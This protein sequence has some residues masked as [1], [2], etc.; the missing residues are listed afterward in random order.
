MLEKLKKRINTITDRLLKKNNI[1]N[2]INKK[3]ND[4]QND[5]NKEAF[6]L[7][8]DLNELFQIVCNGHMLLLRD[9][10]P[11]QANSQ[12]LGILPFLKKIKNEGDNN[13]VREEIKKYIKDNNI[14]R[15]DNPIF[16]AMVLAERQI[17]SDYLLNLFFLVK[18]NNCDSGE[19]DK[20]ANNLFA[21]M[22]KLSPAE[23]IDMF[24]NCFLSIKCFDL[25]DNEVYEKSLNTMLLATLATGNEA[26]GKKILFK[27]KE[28]NLV[29]YNKQTITSYIQYAEKR[30]NKINEKWIYKYVH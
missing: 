17:F 11:I 14:I 15:D 18:N 7:N 9:S 30:F 29:E 5:K 10:W 23:Y 4:A 26:I 21:S 16:Y 20:I 28:R 3:D 19:V 22:L 8:D 1:D 12:T 27:R 24:S 13:E 2:S 6:Q 25:I